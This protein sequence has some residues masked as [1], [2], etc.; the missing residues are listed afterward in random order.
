MS[1]GGVDVEAWVGAY[2]DGLIRLCFL[3]LGDYQLAEDA[4]QECFLRAYRSRARFR[5]ECSPRSWLSGIAVNV[6]RSMLR[7]PWFRRVDR[8][9]ELPEQGYFP[10]LPDDSLAREIGRLPVKY[11]EV[12][13]LHYYRELKLREVARA[14]NIS[15]SAVAMRL[16]RARGM[17]KERLKE[18][19][20]EP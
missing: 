10:E 16:S 18:G 7:T 20:D 4:V 5:G 3:Y 11:R 19:F 1:A 17:L 13:L 14:L 6:C 12:V 9:R 2:G 8:R 15:E